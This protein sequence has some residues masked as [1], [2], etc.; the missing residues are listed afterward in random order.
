MIKDFLEGAAFVLGM[1]VFCGVLAAPIGFMCH[2]TDDP[3]IILP[4]LFVWIIVVGGATG[5]ISR[6]G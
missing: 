5:I 1:T 3:Y 6:R 4:G 2:L